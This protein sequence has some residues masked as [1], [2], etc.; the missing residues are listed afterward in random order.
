MHEDWNRCG[1]KVVTVWARLWG[2]SEKINPGNWLGSVVVSIP[3]T[4]GN[5]CRRDTIIN[6][7]AVRRPKENWRQDLVK[8]GGKVVA[9]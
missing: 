8:A 1:F 9:E 3:E 4:V 7:Q 6:K 2:E 5:G